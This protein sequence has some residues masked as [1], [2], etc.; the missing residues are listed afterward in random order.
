MND[1]NGGLPGPDLTRGVS[2]SRIPDGSI[3]Q[4][5]AHGEPVVLARRGEEL[6]AIG[7]SCSHYGAPLA[8]GLLV[9]DTIR[10][11]WHH[12]CFN[13]HTGEALRAPALDA[14]S[15]WYVEQRDGTVY[16]G[17]SLPLAGPPLSPAASGMP[18]SVV[19]VGGGAAGNA[20]AEMLRREGYSGRIT[21]LSADASIP[22]DRPN[23]SKGYLAGT[24][25][26][27]SNSLRSLEFYREQHIDLKLNARVARIDTATREVILADGSRHAYDALLLATGAEPVRLD[28]PGS[29][30]PHVHYLR[31]LA[32]G[33]AL[34]SKALVS[35]QAVVIGGS[36]IGL[37]VTASL[38]ARNIAVHVVAP[39]AVPMERILGA[40]V[41][42][43]IR[44]LHERNGVTFHL[45]TTV[46]SIDERG[47]TL[48]T[49]ERLA[50]DLVV[51]GI[52]V[53]PSISLAEDAGLAIDRGIVVDEHLETS[54]PGV[55][56]AGDIAR[57]PDR[58]TGERI[59]VEHWVVAERQGQTAARNILGRRERFDAVPF[60]WT[61][62]YDFSLAYVGHA[63]RFDEAKLDGQLDA[64]TRDCTITYR[65]GGRKLA[66]AFVHR[67]LEGLRA[68]VE[69]EMATRGVPHEEKTQGGRSRDME[70]GSRT[71]PRD[72]HQS[73]HQGC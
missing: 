16:V 58:L 23:L 34:V 26:A 45:G 50:A 12:A 73:A 68:E 64:V 3:L 71:R 42:K 21:M 43:F 25:P 30:L 28:I 37:E 11:P 14:I 49:G 36:F 4:G 15:C 31:T 44:R 59:R 69:F 13:L 40:D 61:E 22:C 55:F 70:L 38:R 35:Q 18:E 27:E 2:L 8:D 17:E 32:D 62:Q 56:A 39:D 19:I 41:G 1:T 46:A 54:L 63:E 48:K 10:C 9:G 5:H 67:D 24:A 52:G 6:F 57:W 72:D 47:V 20:A 33:E 7:A 29:D 60:F 53:R 51:V 65:R 66:V